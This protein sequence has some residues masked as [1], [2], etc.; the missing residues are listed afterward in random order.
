MNKKEREI[1][2]EIIKDIDNTDDKI[3]PLERLLTEVKKLIKNG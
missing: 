3:W 1:L 2:S